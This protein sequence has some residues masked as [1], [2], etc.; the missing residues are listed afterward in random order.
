MRER[1]T[2]GLLSFGLATSACGVAVGE[3]VA[4][5]NPPA[6]SPTELTC[7]TDLRVVSSGG[8]VARQSLDGHDTQDRAVDAW[9]R[10]RASLIKEEVDALPTDDGAWVL[11]ADGTAIAKVSFIENKGFTVYGYQVCAPAEDQP[12]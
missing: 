12:D 2:V 7:P 11:R 9:A 3:A 5:V 6:P 8:F 1:L 10:T 4:P